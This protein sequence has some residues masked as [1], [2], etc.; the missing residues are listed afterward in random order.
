MEPK[1]Q[2]C[3]ICHQ[4]R[5]DHNCRKIQCP[6]PGI[7]LL[8]S[9]HHRDKDAVGFKSLTLEQLQKFGVKGFQAVS[10]KEVFV[11][12][13]VLVNSVNQVLHL[14][15][16]TSPPLDSANLAERHY[17]DFVGIILRSVIK[18][19]NE[20]IFG[21]GD[22]KFILWREK[23]LIGIDLPIAGPVELLVIYQFGKFERLVMVIEVKTPEK[24]LLGQFQ[25]TGELL[26]ATKF[27]FHMFDVL[28]AYENHFDYNDAEEDFSTDL[29]ETIIDTAE[30]DPLGRVAKSI[31]RPTFDRDRD[32]PILTE[33]RGFSIQTFTIK[34]I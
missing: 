15:H 6:S 1:A 23:Q 31:S 24:F 7:C 10:A 2:I 27:N 17:E 18:Y 4:E 16:S 13:E 3:S 26:A 32:Q 12:P 30:N 9:K 34:F 5:K 25:I 8:P 33:T 29:I 22:G 20:T 21:D 28:Y 14:F 19:V 11:V